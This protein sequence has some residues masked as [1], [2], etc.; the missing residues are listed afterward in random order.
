MMKKVLLTLTLCATFT[1]LFAQLPCV[2]NQLYRDSAVGVYP[3]PRSTTNPNGGI[4]L[5]AC[6]SNPYYYVLTVKVPTSYLYQGLT[7][8][9]VDSATMNTSGAVTGMPTG[10][11]YACNPPN[12]HFPAN[13]LG[14]VVIRGTAATTNAPGAFP[15]VI[16]LK[17]YTFIAAVDVTFP[18]ALFPG[19]YTLTLLATNST[20]CRLANN[21]LE[22]KIS[23]VKNLPNPFG[24]YTDIQIQS[25]VNDEF[26]FDVFDV[27]G[28][29]VAH[30]TMPLTAGENTYR[31]EAGN[32]ANGIYIYT[33][34]KGDQKFSNKMVISK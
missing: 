2:P 4:T 18:G 21:E 22:G 25:S 8:I 27:T 9:Q 10:L 29:K 6:I 33:I 28:Q 5:P 24:T 14:C 16:A 23:E 20:A 17:L 34:S 31:F 1:A 19:D 3:A 11:N 32:L 12:C 7:P 15:L 13:T 26:Q 30:K